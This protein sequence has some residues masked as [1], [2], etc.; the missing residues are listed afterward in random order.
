MGKKILT[1]L[2][3][4]AVILALVIFFQINPIGG[5][6]VAQTNTPVPTVSRTPTPSPTRT[7][8]PRP[9]TSPTISPNGMI[10]LNVSFTAQAPFGEWSD[11]RQQDGCE[12]ASA[13]MA[14]RWARGQ[15]LTLQQAK[16]EILAISDFEQ[17][18]YGS[19]HDTSVADTISRIFKDYFKFNNVT[20]KYNIDEN[21]IID[22]LE[23]GNLVVVPANGQKLKN[24]NFTPPGPER[25]MLVIKGYDPVKKQF[26]TNDPGTRQGQ[27]YRYS[28]TTMMAAIYDYKTGYHEPVTEI[29]K[30]M[31]VVHK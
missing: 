18:K 19:Y 3:G 8:T 15:S 17:E 24:P 9:T 25:H 26:I 11:Q 27:S 23:K 21:D 16:V 5:D 29:V 31:I 2:V 20:A 10:L 1:T 6:E 13:L 28:V 7:A 22:E 30:A 12:E 4:V 14:V